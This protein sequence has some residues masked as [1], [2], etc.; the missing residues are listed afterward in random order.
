MKKIVYQLFFIFCL[1][2]VYAKPGSLLTMRVGTD[3][4]FQQKPIVYEPGIVLDTRTYFYFTETSL[5][6][7]GFNVN[8]LFLP[9]ILDES[10]SLLEIGALASLYKEFSSRFNMRF[11]VTTGGNVGVLNNSLTDNY[12]NTNGSPWGFGFFAAADVLAGF[13]ITPDLLLTANVGYRFSPGLYNGLNASVGATIHIP[14]TTEKVEITEVKTATVIPAFRKFYLD[15]PVVRID[16]TNNERFLMSNV[17]VKVLTGNLTNESLP[18]YLPEIPTG[19]TASIYVP[20]EWNEK[21]LQRKSTT[22]ETLNFEINY[23]AGSKKRTIQ[24]SGICLILGHN[25]FVWNYNSQS[26]ETGDE[27]LDAVFN[28]VDGKAAVFVDP[29]NEDMIELSH[30]IQNQYLEEVGFDALNPKMKT[31]YRTLAFLKSRKIK[32]QLDPDSVPYGK[33]SGKVDYLRYPSETLRAGYG[34]CDDL[35]ILFSQLLE[36][37]GVKC[38]FITTPGHIFVAAESEMNGGLINTLFGSTEKFIEKSGRYY[39]PMEVTMFNESFEKIWETGLANWN[40]ASEEERE[41]FLLDEQWQEFKPDSFDAI[42]DV[43]VFYPGIDYINIVKETR[44]SLSKIAGEKQTDFPFNSASYSQLARREYTFGELDSAYEHIKQA[45]ALKP[46]YSNLYN[47]GL[48]ANSMGKKFDAIMHL[49]Q[50]IALKPDNKAEKL[51]ARINANSNSNGI[52]VASGENSTDEQR[53]GLTE[54]ELSWAEE[55]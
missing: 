29:N 43:T 19:E 33:D 9:T 42:S 2:L 49:N 4:M 50:A 38:A 26:N 17:S 20:V 35:S 3:Y 36:S 12:N 46:T 47:A 30:Q 40:N 18:I 25:N 10:V 14:L 24:T 48:I 21:I 28:A 41:I 11:D 52:Y 51:L 6:Q 27:L 45:V 22:A 32:Y 55:E 13:Y 7:F 15:Y 1:T 44:K 31:I 23:K 53:A 54:E 5:F 39:I 34:D 37:G 8:Y 16:L